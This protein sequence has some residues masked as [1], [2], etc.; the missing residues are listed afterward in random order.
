[1]KSHHTGILILTLVFLIGGLL[2]YTLAQNGY[3]P[4]AR[5]NGSFIS[6]Q[7]VKENADVSRRL[8]AQGLAGA[9]PELDNLFKRGSEKDLLK[10]SLENL[11]TN[12]IIKSAAAGEELAKAQQEVEN[13]FDAKTVAN[14]SGVLQNVYSWD[15]AKFKKRI[16]EPQALLQIVAQSK[17]QDFDSWLKSAKSNSQVKIWFLPYKWEE[18]NLVNK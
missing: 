2:S 10:N 1:M 6:Y 8:Y 3:F 15:A 16:L 12:A 4:V 17:G 9:S 5:V 7:T 18:G 13:N 14:L 11:I